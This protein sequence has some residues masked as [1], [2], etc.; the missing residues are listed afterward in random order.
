[1]H[2]DPH[3]L[4]N[5]YNNRSC[6]SVFICLVV[7]RTDILFVCTYAGVISTHSALDREDKPEHS[8]EV[9]VKFVNN[10]YAPL[11]ITVQTEGK[12]TSGAEVDASKMYL[13]HSGEG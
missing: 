13:L 6:S 1:M 2:A 8:V 5:T 3:T 12:K 9:R 10:V 7:I 4:N 11:W